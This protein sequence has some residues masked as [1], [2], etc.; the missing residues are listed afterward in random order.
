MKLDERLTWSFNKDV[1]PLKV[2]LG[3]GHNP[4]DG[5][6]NVDRM[7]LEGVD[8]VANLDDPDK[9]TLPFDDDSVDEYLAVDLVE[10]LYYPLPFFDEL[11]RCAKP[12][13]KFETALP[14][15]TSDDAFED[16]THVRYYVLG[17]WRY[18]AQP[19]YYRADYGY[20]G[21]WQVRQIVLD[22]APGVASEDEL[23]SQLMMLRNVALRQY[24]TLEAIKPARVRDPELLEAPAVLF[25]KVSR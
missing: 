19:I 16:P 21:D 10:H 6:V 22:V 11:Y 1:S 3:C 2:N 23:F 12:G 24:V 25:R 7:P 9:V 15:G 4:L 17:S 14:Y 5:Y 18:F 20:R 13:A 8:V